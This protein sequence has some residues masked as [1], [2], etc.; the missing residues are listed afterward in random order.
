MQEVSETTQAYLENL[1]LD[2]RE[3]V[4]L[5]CDVQEEFGLQIPNFHIVLSNTYRLLQAGRLFY[6][7]LHSII[8][9]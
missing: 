6:V 9:D 8:I 3:T 2:P 5:L 4:F 1:D 7:R